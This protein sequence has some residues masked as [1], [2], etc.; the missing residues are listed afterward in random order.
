M[1]K[2][3][4]QALHA[5]ALAAS[6]PNQTVVVMS[7]TDLAAKAN[8]RM[9]FEMVT[10]L[11]GDAE[12]KAYHATREIRFQNGSKIVFRAGEEQLRGLRVDDIVRD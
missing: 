10:P 2:G 4:I 5:L 7:S 9:Y 11:F 8:F 3:Y 1:R 6:K 12:A